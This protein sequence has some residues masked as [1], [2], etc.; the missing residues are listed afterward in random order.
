VVAKKIK[1]FP[2]GLLV[3]EF[4]EGKE[5]GVAFLGG[6]FCR[7]LGA[8][9]MDY[10]QYPHIPPYLTYNAKWEA[11]CDEFKL[12]T[13]SVVTTQDRLTK[14][15]ITLAQRAASALRC[16]SYF[17]VDIRERNGIPYILDIN[18]NPDINRDSG[19]IKQEYH[20]G[21]TYDEVIGRIVHLADRRK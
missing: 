14:R 16:R 12:L 21:Y 4:I 15:I 5:Y 11:D 17:R 7:P 9:L 10:T 13:P 19:F 1:E 6:L 20:K 18:P 2:E 3:E 8:S